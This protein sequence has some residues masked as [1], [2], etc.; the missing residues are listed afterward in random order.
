MHDG[1]PT[2]LA[3]KENG[4]K[5]FRLYK[6]LCD[7]KPPERILDI[8]CGIGRKT[9]L[10]T[11]HLSPQGTYVGMDIVKSGIDWC[12]TRIHPGAQR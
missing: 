12:S 6:D 11:E 7:L 9:F 3:F 5:F 1:P 10:L 2:Y 8:G 4:E